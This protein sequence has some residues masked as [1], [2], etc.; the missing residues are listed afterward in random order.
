MRYNVDLRKEPINIAFIVLDSL[1]Y[2]IAYKAL[3]PN[4]DKL[5]KF[6]QAWSCGWF[7][8]PVH[9]AL[10]HNAW[11]PQSTKP[12]IYNYKT[13]RWFQVFN[14]RTHHPGLGIRHHYRIH[15]D[16]NFVKA[17]ES[18]GYETVGIG[19]VSWF[20]TRACLSREIWRQFF[21]DGIHWQT[22]FSEKVSGA[23]ENQLAYMEGLLLPKK[24]KLFFFINISDTHMPYSFRGQMP[25]IHYV[26]S[27]FPKLLS[28]LPK[29]IHIFVFA[30]HGDCRG[31]DGLYGHKIYHP[32]LLEVPILNRIIEA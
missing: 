13:E 10:F 22:D 31:E 24:E 4:I 7:T 18:L 16:V 6:T 5:G 12:G 1:R 29:P 3:T 2:D 8:L 17:L 23:F 21:K 15:D 32:K 25:A 28:L 27:H 9:L 26:D 20:D 14:V 19:G 30:D 11:L